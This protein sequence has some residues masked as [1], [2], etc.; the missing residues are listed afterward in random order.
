MSTAKVTTPLTEAQV[1]KI[2]EMLAQEYTVAKIARRLDIHPLTI[3][4]IKDGTSQYTIRPKSETNAP[5]PPPP[6]K[7]ARYFEDKKQ[8]EWQPG[9]PTQ[10]EIQEQIEVFKQRHLADKRT[11]TGHGPPTESVAVRRALSRGIIRRG[12][13]FK[14]H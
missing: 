10:E 4:K 14:D 5:A 3:Q 9:M 7:A 8:L 6:V 1:D 11:S 2:C 12:P 13:G